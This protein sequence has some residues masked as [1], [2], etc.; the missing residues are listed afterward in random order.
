LLFVLALVV[1][2]G[3]AGWFFPPEGIKLGNDLVLKFP[4][5]R[6][7]FSEPEQKADISKVLEAVNKIDTTFRIDEPGEAID[8]A[9]QVMPAVQLNMNLQYTSSSAL[10][11][12]FDAIH[13]LR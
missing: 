2:M 4:S 9:A 10:K 13:R 12:F 1:L 11:K 7:L 5:P 6:D 3:L 8:T